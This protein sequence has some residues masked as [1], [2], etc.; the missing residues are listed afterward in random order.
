MEFTSTPS[1]YN[2]FYR[3]GFSSVT[4][5][6]GR[7]RL[8]TRYILREHAGPLAFAVATLTS[9]LLLNYISKR[10]EDLVG[11]GL[12]WNVIAEFFVL[13]VPF[14]IAMTLPMAVLIA[15]LYAFSRLA[16]DSELTAMMSCG[17]GT[18]QLMTPVLGAGLAL[19]LLMVAFNDQLLPRANYRLNGLL[20]TISQKKPTFNLKPQT[21]NEVTDGQVFLWLARLDRSS[22]MMYDVTIYDLADPQIRN[23][24]VADSGLLAFAPNGRDLLLTLYSGY[25]QE[26]RGLI[27]DRLQRVAFATN[28]MRVADV[29]NQL[30]P[31]ED[32]G[33]KGDR[34]MGV[35][36]MQSVI[37]RAQ[38]ERDAKRAELALIDSGLA[39]KVPVRHGGRIGEWYCGTID[40]VKKAA[41]SLRPA[42]A[43]AQGAVDRQQ[44]AKQD[45]ATKQDSSNAKPKASGVRPG[46][47]PVI[48]PPGE[49]P[50]T[51]RRGN[52]AQQPMTPEV[53]TASL[54]LEIESS[55]RRINQYEVEI[56][57]KFAISLACLVFALLGPPIALRFPR[58]GVGLVIGVS[59][60]VFAIYYVGLI[61]GE[62]LADKLIVSPVIAMWAANAL[63]AL[64]GIALMATM[65][66]RGASP[67]GGGFS[68]LFDRLLSWR[69]RPA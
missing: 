12:P 34:E 19:S 6:G 67:R 14:T 27:A 36:E 31:T 29:A 49:T 61:A 16:S 32:A 48:M 21:L 3:T 20:A 26:T 1:R 59:I 55:E 68:E 28:V 52:R 60:S 44:S 5:P 39:R 64:V 41:R 50:S 46:V 62:K 69:R 25:V 65:G 2:P 42:P 24:I 9:L 13:S 47:P 11:K 8:V 7:L 51:F 66:K 17:V 33:Y 4:S 18:R 57:K 35:C 38:R 40:A 56:H 43:G 45:T 37:E 15:T 23:T 58:S 63:L 10:F 54:Q 30:M 53:R 22:N